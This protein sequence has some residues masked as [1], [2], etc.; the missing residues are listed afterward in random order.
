M[1]SDIEIETIYLAN[2]NDTIL[3]AFGNDLIV[4]KE[5][6]NGQSFCLQHNTVYDYGDDE[7]ALVPPP[8]E[9]T[10]SQLFVYQLE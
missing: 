2:G 1:K 6:R 8:G 3:F 9:F 7:N 5:D 4:Y 10:I